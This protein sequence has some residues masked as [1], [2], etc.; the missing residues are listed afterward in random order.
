MFVS[1]AKIDELIASDGAYLD[2]TTELLRGC[3]DL[4][5]PARLTI[6]TRENLVFSGGQIVAK[7]AAKFGCA[8]QNLPPEGTK[9]NAGEEIFSA[10]GSFEN[11]HKIWKI[12]QISLEYSCKIS[13]YAHEMLA[14]MRAQN[15]RCALGATRKSFPFAKELC[16]NALIA[17]G[18][19]MHRLGLH[20]SVL[21]FDN[22]VRAFANFREFCENIALFKARA[23]ERKIMIEV[24]SEREFSELLPYAP[25]ALMCDK[26]SSDE[27]ARCVKIRDNVAPGVTLCAAGGINKSNCAD[28]AAAG[29]DCLVTSAVWTQGTCDLSGKIEFI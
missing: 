14:L 29:A 4:D 1:D 10:R 21:F 19:T 24:A 16:A 12:C 6:K 7:I 25:D 15:P 18:G 3:A 28:Y 2:L 8:A 26:M 22:H 17:G 5:A 9:F 13:T 20:D 27:V 11:L 23:P